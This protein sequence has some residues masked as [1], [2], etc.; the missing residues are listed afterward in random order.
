M[1][2]N[3]NSGDTEVLNSNVEFRNSSSHIVTSKNFQPTI[4][5][6][7]GSTGRI[8]PQDVQLVEDSVITSDSYGS[9]VYLKWQPLQLSSHQQNTINSTIKEESPISNTELY[10]EGGNNSQYTV[11]NLVIQTVSNNDEQLKN[12]FQDIASTEVC[13]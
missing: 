1:L 12:S 8:L 10:I 3:G 6:T 7:S 5:M 9:D 11:G 4:I 13:I 2:P